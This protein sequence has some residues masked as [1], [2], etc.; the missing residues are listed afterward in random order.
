MG[1]FSDIF[2]TNQNSSPPPHRYQPQHNASPPTPH[3][4]PKY[5]NSPSRPAQR[6]L[7]ISV[8]WGRNEPVDLPLASVQQYRQCTVHDIKLHCKA[9]FHIPLA[10]MTLK[11][12]NGFLRDD[13]ATLESLGILPGSELVVLG[14]QVLVSGIV[15]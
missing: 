2:G 8:R 4:D 11:Y 6:P 13:Q 1:L 3:K 5:Q 15:I 14:D 9:L 12:N 10:T 7:Y